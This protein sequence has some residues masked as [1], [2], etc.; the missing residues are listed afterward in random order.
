[1]ILLVWQYFQKNSA[2]QCTRRAH[3]MSGRRQ[4]VMPH[5]IFK[6]CILVREMVIKRWAD[7]ASF[8]CYIFDRD[9]FHRIFTKQVLEAS[10]E[11]I[12]RR[13][14]FSFLQHIYPSF[15]VFYPIT[16][17]GHPF[18]AVC[19]YNATS[20]S[21]SSSTSAINFCTLYNS[22]AIKRSRLCPNILTLLVF[23][24]SC[25]VTSSHFASVI[26]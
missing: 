16:I 4:Q 13:L 6:Q 26:I 12:I 20:G 17:R 15:S 21:I 22:G 9:F 8:V 23:W 18:P 11:Q 7:H 2:L 10:R 19:A 14:S 1:M 24:I 25:A 5:N 3:K